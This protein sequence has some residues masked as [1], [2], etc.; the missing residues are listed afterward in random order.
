MDRFTDRDC[1]NICIAK[2]E[3]GRAKGNWSI[4]E[5]LL[6]DQRTNF[7]VGERCQ[8][9]YTVPRSQVIGNIVAVGHGK[10]QLWELEVESNSKNHW[11]VIW[12][13]DGP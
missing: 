11:P 4:L 2:I 13:G 3:V 12:D 5:A 6:K 1:I 10:G 9:G 7:F 8:V